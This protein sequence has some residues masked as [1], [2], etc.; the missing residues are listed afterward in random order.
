VS[1]LQHADEILVLDH[2]RVV[3]R[4]D[5]AALMALD[6]EYAALYRRQQLEERLEAEPA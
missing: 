4:G 6:G 3:E 5:H 2:G 1:A